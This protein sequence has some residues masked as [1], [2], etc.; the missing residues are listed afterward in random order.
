MIEE[1]NTSSSKN[2]MAMYFV[3]QFSLILAT[4]SFLMMEMYYFFGLG[5]IAQ[6]ILIGY[7]VAKYSGS[8]NS[9]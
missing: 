7:I 1:Q 6:L 2:D 9:Q 5:I 4:A 3:L 8:K